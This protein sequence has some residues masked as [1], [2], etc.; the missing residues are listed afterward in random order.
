MRL[1]IDERTLRSF[2]NRAVR[3]Y[4]EEVIS[5]LVVSGKDPRM[6]RVVPFRRCRSLSDETWIGVSV[7]VS[8][9][10]RLKRKYGPRLVGLIHTHPEGDYAPSSPDLDLWDW[11]GLPL[12]AICAMAK[13]RRGV[14][15]T[16]VR[17][18][19]RIS[20]ISVRISS[21]RK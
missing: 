2:L 14:F 12:F 7:P 17:I 6:L 15:R 11:T 13:T 10:K 9:L 20:K 21:S 5:A 1:S 18:W 4:P 8:E 3:F 19:R 16:G